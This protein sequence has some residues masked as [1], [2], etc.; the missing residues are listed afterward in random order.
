MWVAFVPGIFQ[1]TLKS[2]VSRSFFDASPL[3]CDPMCGQ[4]GKQRFNETGKEITRDSV[5]CGRILRVLPRQ[6]LLRVL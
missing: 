3:R 6:W 2:K 5:V 4:R 1:N